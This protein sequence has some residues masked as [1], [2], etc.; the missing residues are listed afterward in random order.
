ML[1]KSEIH[2][3]SVK[4]QTSELNIAREYCQH[5]F[6]SNFYKKN[7]Q[8][9]FKGGTALRIIFNSSRF[10]EDLD[11]SSQ[12]NMSKIE[13]H[14]ENA[15]DNSA[16]EG[17][18]V[19]ILE[20]KSTSG[21]YLSIVNYK[22]LDYII[23]I[24]LQ[25]SQRKT[26]LNSDL[27][28]IS[29]SYISNYTLLVLQQDD[30]VNEKIMAAIERRKPRDFYDIYFMLRARLITPEQR[31]LLSEVLKSFNVSDIDISKEL[32]IFLPQS[33]H[34]IVGNFDEVFRAELKRFIE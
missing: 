16:H 3:M 19:G 7:P 20:A 27:H 30:L 4:N 23:E 32:K 6:L 10:S 14:V 24:S 17:F 18:D 5:V 25:I 9:F 33:L 11:F 26:A 22:F 31:K 13:Q 12:L 21:G 2:K 8:I 15:L 29:N 1:D 28:V 34:S